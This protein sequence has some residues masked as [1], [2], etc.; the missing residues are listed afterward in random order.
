MWASALEKQT[1]A[2]SDSVSGLQNFEHKQF[3]RKMPH[4]EHGNSELDKACPRIEAL[5]A[6]EL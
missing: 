3:V 2:E 4:L 1:I 5:D 6:L